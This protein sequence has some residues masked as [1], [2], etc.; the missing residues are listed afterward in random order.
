MSYD[1]AALVR[2]YCSTIYKVYN[3]QSLPIQHSRARACAVALAV[4][5]NRALCNRVLHNQS[6]RIV[7]LTGP[8]QG[9][10]MR[11]EE[12]GA[13]GIR[14]PPERPRSWERRPTFLRPG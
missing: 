13:R 8:S 12:G 4:A 9:A 2:V 6:A 3:I 1:L 7:L 10:D 14:S 11:L 5:V